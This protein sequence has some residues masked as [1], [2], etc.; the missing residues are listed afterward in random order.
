MGN[1]LVT[2]RFSM[3]EGLLKGL[4]YGGIDHLLDTDDIGK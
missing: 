4:T 3:K 1:G 2:I